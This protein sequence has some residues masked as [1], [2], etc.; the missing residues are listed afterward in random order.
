MGRFACRIQDAAVRVVLKKKGLDGLVARTLS[1]VFDQE[2][3]RGEGGASPDALRRRDVRLY[4]DAARHRPSLQD[5]RRQRV[6]RRLVG[7]LHEFF[8]DR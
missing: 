4:G 8:H 3:E 2:S 5:W 6:H 7:V 1:C